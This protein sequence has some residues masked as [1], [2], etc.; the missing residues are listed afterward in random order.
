MRGMLGREVLGREVLDRAVD[1]ASVVLISLAAVLS[2]ICGYQSGRW[3][4]E[5]TLFYNTANADRTQAAKDDVN[6]AVLASM[7]VD[8]FLRYADAY[9]RHDRKRL[10]FLYRWMRPEL[11]PALDAWLATHP[12]ENPKAPSSP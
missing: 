6:A 12:L 2:A 9:E 5:Q 3:G 8:M 7:D 4:G 1:V 10:E 11:R